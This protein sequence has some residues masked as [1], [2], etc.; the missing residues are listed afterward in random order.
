MADPAP[1]APE[2]LVVVP[3]AR[4]L[5]R[6]EALLALVRWMTHAG[7]PA[8]TVLCWQSG[9]LVG[10]FAAEAPVIDAG[11]VNDDLAAR[12][13][14]AVGF[15]PVAR[16]LK[17]RR[18]RRLLAP[19]AAC[20]Q[21]L[22]GGASTA[23]LLEW[24][25]PR[26]HRDVAIWLG[27]DELAAV[28]RVL[29]MATSFLVTGDD[30]AAALVAAGASSARIRRVAEPLVPRPAAPPVAR[31]GHVVAVAGTDPTD[32]MAGLVASVAAAAGR[33]GTA[34][35][36]VHTDLDP[37]W[38]RWSDPRFAGFEGLVAD[39]SVD[40]CR[41]RFDDLAALVLVGPD[42]ATLAAEAAVS[43]VPVLSLSRTGD[44]V[45]VVDDAQALAG[46]LGD[47][48]DDEVALGRAREDA[49]RRARPHLVDDAGR[50][51][52]AAFDMGAP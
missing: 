23:V 42:G 50:A 34:V 12:A 1:G 11:A 45:A 8:P 49:M 35:A 15:T 25:P 39:W 10:H 14:A 36:L 3:E 2:L 48:L 29:P 17:S 13:L 43:G 4:L 44:A 40:E 52:M 7:G 26:A 18:L 9:P 24:L 30:T 47:L 41:R 46:R 21:I 27:D 51:V 33:P 19:L 38:A 5:P 28:D 22:L 6:T 37:C 16:G 32:A 31:P 20:P